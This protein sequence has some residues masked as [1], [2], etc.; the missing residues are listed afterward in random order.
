MVMS[1]FFEYA[2]SN[3]LL[4]FIGVIWLIEKIGEAVAAV[5]KAC[6]GRK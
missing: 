5:V 6:R 4:V 1:E 2:T 3:G